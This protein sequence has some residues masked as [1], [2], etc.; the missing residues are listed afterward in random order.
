[1]SDMAVVPRSR[2]EIAGQALDVALVA[3]LFELRRL[4]DLVPEAVTAALL[5][6]TPL[7]LLSLRVKRSNLARWGRTP[8]MGLSKG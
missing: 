4:W 3:A 1:M 6:M 2:M 7:S 8:L 5:A